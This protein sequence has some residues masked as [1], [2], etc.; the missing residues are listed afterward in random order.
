M[1]GSSQSGGKNREKRHPR[2]NFRDK[3]HALAHSAEGSPA[4]AIPDHPLIP[5]GPVRLVDSA[6][7]LAELLGELRRAGRFAYD[8]EFIG[9]MSY[10]PKLCLIQ[11][12][13]HEHVIL[14]DPLADLDLKAFWE[15]IADP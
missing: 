11:V 3:S 8:S 2:H 13:T 5:K 4:A 1:S 9:E 15:L 12:A 6:D 7:A 10:H 14:I